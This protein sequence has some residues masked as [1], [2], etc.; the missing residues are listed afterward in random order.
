M[1]NM[2]KILPC[3]LSTAIVVAAAAAVLTPST[4]HAYDGTNCKAPGNCWEPK[5]GFPATVA[6]SKYDPK[7][8]PKELNKQSESIQAMEGRNQQ[9]VNN[10]KKTGTFEYDTDKIAQ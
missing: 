6:G 8:N 7:H 2:R 4:A 1:T 10:F 5:P 3:L 9:R